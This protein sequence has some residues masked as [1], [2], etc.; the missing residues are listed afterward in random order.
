MVQQHGR[1]DKHGNL[2]SCNPKILM[3]TDI[4]LQAI[5]QNQNNG[6]V[7]VYPKNNAISPAIDKIE[8]ARPDLSIH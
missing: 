7:D 2:K 5:G 4:I 1:N 8:C 3:N 6:N